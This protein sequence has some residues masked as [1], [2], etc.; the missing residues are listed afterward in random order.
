MEKLDNFGNNYY[1]TS[2]RPINCLIKIDIQDVEKCLNFSY[3]MSFGA[4]GEHRNRRSGGQHNRKNG[5]IFCNT[6][7]GKIAEIALFNYLNNN[8]LKVDYPDFSIMKL[9]E[10]DSIDLK[11]NDK[12]IAVKST[13]EY[14]N[15]LLLETADWDAKANYIPNYDNESYNVDFFVLNRIMPDSTALLKQKRLYYSNVADI[16]ELKEIILDKNWQID[17]VGFS[18]K[19]EIKKIIKNEFI[20]PKNAILNERTK[21]DAENYYIQAGDMHIIEDLISILN[22]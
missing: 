20:L 18:T 22:E 6:F 17:L 15:L 4:T 12:N 19:E 9:G 13:K 8:N 5:E 1:I 2:K 7:H 11:C 3:D 10:W 16:E 14:G 21:M